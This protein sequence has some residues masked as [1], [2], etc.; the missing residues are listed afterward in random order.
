MIIKIFFFQLW[1][2]LVYLFLACH[3]LLFSRIGL[4]GFPALCRRL[5]FVFAAL[6]RADPPRLT[7]EQLCKVVA[8]NMFAVHNTQLS[9]GEEKQTGKQ[10]KKMENNTQ[11]SQGKGKKNS[12][13]SSTGETVAIM[14]AHN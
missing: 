6:L 7:S 1:K 10:Y 9:Q 2:H 4:D 3:G 11:L 14:I 13:S 8:L 12:Q 5:L